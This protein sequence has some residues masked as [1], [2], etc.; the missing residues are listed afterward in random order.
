MRQT[1]IIGS[2]HHKAVPEPSAL[3]LCAALSIFLGQLELFKSIG[4]ITSLR[5]THRLPGLSKVSMAPP[6]VPGCIALG[7]QLPQRC[8]QLDSLCLCSLL[9][10]PGSLRC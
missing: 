3:I 10:N 6:M 1:C 2:L 7:P 5:G 4:P 8:A 9:A